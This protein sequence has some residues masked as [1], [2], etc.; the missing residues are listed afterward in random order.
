MRRAI[1]IG[2]AVV[3]AVLVG[4]TIASSVRGRTAA[5]K[6]AVRGVVDAEDKVFFDDPHVRHA[7]A[8][9]GYVLTTDAVDGPAVP[10]AVARA[11][12]DFAFVAQPWAQSAAVAGNVAV[13]I[14]PFS[15]RVAIATSTDVA[16]VLQ[17]RGV[18]RDHG[19]WW[20]LD[21]AGYRDLVAHGGAPVLR[22]ADPTTSAT[23]QLYAAAA[24]YASN[25][26]RTLAGAADVDAVVNQVAPLFVGQGYVAETSEQLVTAYTSGARSSPAMIAADESEYVAHGHFPPTSVL[27]YPEPA[28]DAQLSVVPLTAAGQRVG[29]VLASDHALQEL[30]AEHGFRTP[31]TPKDFD[32]TVRRQHI[33]VEP[34]DVPTLPLPSAEAL[35]SLI[36]RIDAARYSALGPRTYP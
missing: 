27:L 12:Y 30:A 2:I 16:H 26:A 11:P 6:V 32:A 15:T 20:T 36:D 7:L 28:I 21:L 10:A 1:S 3:L 4:A 18:A 33:V 31:S 24:A 14:S 8:D 25:G 17:Q 19:G 9:R 29:R 23:A 35:Q 22:S 13:T 5:K 34:R